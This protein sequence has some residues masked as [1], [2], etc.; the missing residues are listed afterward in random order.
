MAQQVYMREIH[1]V[2]GR[3][4]FIHSDTPVQKPQAL[5]AKRAALLAKISSA[6]RAEHL[7]A[8]GLHKQ[9]LATQ[10]DPTG[11]LQTVLEVVRD[12]RAIDQRV[13]VCAVVHDPL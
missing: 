5:A 11:H 8:L 10:N 9:Q 12:P 6:F 4:K 7:I 1:D 2:D 13:A 3:T